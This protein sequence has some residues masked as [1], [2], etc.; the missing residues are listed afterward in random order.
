[1]KLTRKQA[2]HLT[3]DVMWPELA[4]TGQTKREYFE[5]K[6]EPLH[7]CYL[8]EYAQP[9]YD[10]KKVLWHCPKCPYYQHYN[11]RCVSGVYRK[12]Q[13]E[14]DKVEEDKASRTL[15]K[16]YAGKFVK[17]LEPIK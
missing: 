8:C 9:K 4:E 12:W 14:E 13:N 10:A 5:G 11:F 6:E 3:R 1:M 15:L 7:G 2:I 16:K 17:E